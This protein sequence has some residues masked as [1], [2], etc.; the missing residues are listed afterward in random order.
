MSKAGER[1]VANETYFSLLVEDALKVGRVALGGNAGLM[2]RHI[3]QTATEN[4]LLG[5]IVRDL[6]RPE[7]PVKSV[8][9][10]FFFCRCLFYFY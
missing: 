3:F 6:T 4:V 10:F 2:A 7:L 1:F 9:F 5:G 8:F